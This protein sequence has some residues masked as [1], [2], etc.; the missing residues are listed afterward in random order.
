LERRAPLADVVSDANRT[1]IASIAGLLRS[2]RIDGRDESMRRTGAQSR[3]R[4]TA[5]RPTYWRKVSQASTCPLFKPMVSHFCRI[6]DDP[7]VKLSGTA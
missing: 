7:W 1:A 4:G 2:A 6:A 5:D 3:T